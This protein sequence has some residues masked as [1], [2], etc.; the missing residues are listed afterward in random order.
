[1][2]EATDTVGAPPA[3]APQG[4]DRSGAPLVQASGVWKIFG[5]RADRIIGTPDAD[6][7]LSLIHI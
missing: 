4:V 6:L 1:M 3:E 2:S 5:S 7:P